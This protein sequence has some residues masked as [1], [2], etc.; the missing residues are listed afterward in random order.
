MNEDIGEDRSVY[1]V[2]LFK[3]S[4][5]QNLFLLFSV[6]FSFRAGLRIPLKQHEIRYRPLIFSS[7]L[8]LNRWLSTRSAGKPRKYKIKIDSLATLEFVPE[9]F[10]SVT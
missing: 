1:A 3:S 7:S 8:T 4:D 5:A 9:L 2:F 6:T 10:S